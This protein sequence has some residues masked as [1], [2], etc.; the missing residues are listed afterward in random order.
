MYT[1]YIYIYNIHFYLA[2]SSIV[3]F[4]TLRHN[5][6]S[7]MLFMTKFLT[8]LIDLF[9]LFDLQQITL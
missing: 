3:T 1:Y 4:I 6:C 2:C 9:L 8:C 5:V 7:P